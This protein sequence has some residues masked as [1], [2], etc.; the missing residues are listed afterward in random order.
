M[1]PLFAKLRREY[2]NDQL[3]EKN[4]HPNPFKQFGRWFR[5]AIKHNPN[6]EAM[7]LATASPKGFVTARTV[8]LKDFGKKGFSFY[9]YYQSRKGKQI[10]KNPKGALVFY[11]PELNRQISMTGKIRKVS[12]TE[13]LRYF[14]SRPVKS[15]IAAWVSYQSQ[16]IGSRQELEAKFN[17]ASQRF[18]GKAIPLPPGWGGYRLVPATIEFWQGRL[19]RLNDRLQYVRTKAGTW[20]LRRLQP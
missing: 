13:S 17:G 5:E 18:Q 16:P 12:K 15:Q 1:K 4:L 20:K 6:P 7:T 8:L 9:S 2:T 10:A 19:N 11:W 3:L 14:H